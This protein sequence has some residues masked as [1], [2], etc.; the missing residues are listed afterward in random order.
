ME[1]SSARPGS[2][3]SGIQRCTWAH[4]KFFCM[5]LY[6]CTC[7]MASAALVLKALGY[8]VVTGW[9]KCG[10]KWSHGVFAWSGHTHWRAGTSC[11][12]SAYRYTH[13]R[14]VLAQVCRNTNYDVRKCIY[15]HGDTLLPALRDLL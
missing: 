2:V 13:C 5:R 6:S 7:S 8:N 15:R 14:R 4:R 12:C 11:I 9:G 10:S 3:M 1:R